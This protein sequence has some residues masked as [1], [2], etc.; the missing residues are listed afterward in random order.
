MTINHDVLDLICLSK[1]T[2]QRHL[3]ENN[4]NSTTCSHFKAAV[5]NA[6][7]GPISGFVYTLRLYRAIVHSEMVG[8]RLYCLLVYF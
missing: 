2:V 3:S 4:R 6:H 1:V 5:H 7:N 8:I